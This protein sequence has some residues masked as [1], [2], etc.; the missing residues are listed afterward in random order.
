M[1]VLPGILAASPAAPLFWPPS[2]LGVDSAWYG[3]VPFAHWLTTALRPRRV[4]ELG[5]HHGVSFAAFCEAVRRGGFP[6]D[7]VAVDAW[8]GDAHAGFY[9]SMV[10]DDLARFVARHYGRI[11]RLL[12]MRFDAALE[13]VADGSVDLLHVDGRH[14]YEDVRDDFE[15]WRRKLSERAVVLFHDTRE[16]Q[17]DFG[18]HRYWAELTSGAPSFEFHH[19]HGLG[20]LAAG[21]HTPPA[22]AWLCALRDHPAAWTVRERFAHFGA[23]WEAEIRARRAEAGLADLR[24]HAAS[25][26]AHIDALGAYT[27]R[28]EGRVGA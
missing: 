17:G 26:Q 9:G 13:H 4:V 25:L 2:R 24:A 22:A 12:R 14:R 15:G 3:H 8:E 21:A 20:V 28:L 18:V 7:C 23:I 27:A 10:H 1:D 6:C 11:G 5:T 16:Q 19:A